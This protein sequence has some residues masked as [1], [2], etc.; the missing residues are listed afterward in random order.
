M[1]AVRVLLG[2]MA[3][4][5]LVTLCLLVYVVGGDLRWRW[6]RRRFDKWRQRYE[7]IYGSSVRDEFERGAP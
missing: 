6:K 7:A 4:L 3:V 2:A 1:I 5:G